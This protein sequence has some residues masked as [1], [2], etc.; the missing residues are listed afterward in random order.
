MDNQIKLE[1]IERLIGKLMIA[2]FY[3]EQA[4]IKQME[5]MQMQIQQL[6]ATGNRED[7]PLREA[8]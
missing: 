6:T 5:Q 4:I 3:N 1:D 7:G 2:N 8:K